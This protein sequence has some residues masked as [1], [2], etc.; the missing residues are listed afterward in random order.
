MKKIEKAN[1]GDE[2]VII[3]NQNFINCNFNEST[4]VYKGEGPVG[5]QGCTFNSIKWSFDSYARNTMGFLH[6]LYHG[7][8]VVGMHLVDS[9]FNKIKESGPMSSRISNIEQLNDL[10]LKLGEYQRRIMTYDFVIIEYSK[11]PVFRYALE[12]VS[13]EHIREN[14]LFDVKANTV[15]EAVDEIKEKISQSLKEHEARK[16]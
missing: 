5:F 3:D 10:P 9:L 8:G 2:L 16:E 4:L 12:N 6:G 14:L 15:K 11:K 13:E 7:M 1:F